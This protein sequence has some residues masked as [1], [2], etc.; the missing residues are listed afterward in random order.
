MD[1]ISKELIAFIVRAK[2]N[3]WNSNGST[4]LAYRPGSRDLQYH[5]PDLAYM[6][7]YFGSTDFLGQEIVWQN[8]TPIWA[9]NYHGQILRSDL[10]DGARAGATSQIGRGNVYALQT[11]LGEYEFA[12]EHSVFRMST[13]G[14]AT[15]FS[16]SEWHEVNGVTA[17]RFDFHG[18]LVRD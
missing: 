8:G 12:L 13:V 18:G 9:M 4:S 10:Y 16:G 1:T 7:S 5:E 2:A 15:G 11:F 6:D 3:T 14:D 17:Y